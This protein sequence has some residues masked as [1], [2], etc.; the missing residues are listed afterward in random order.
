MSLFPRVPRSFSSA[1]RPLIRPPANR[2]LDYDGQ[3][4]A[5]IGK[6]GRRTQPEDANDLLRLRLC[7]RRHEPRL[8]ASRQIQRDAGQDPGQ[9][10]FH[11]L[12]AGARSDPAQLNAPP[13]LTRVIAAIRQ[14]NSLSRKMFPIR[15]RNAHGST[16]TTLQPGDVTITGTINDNTANAS[17][18]LGT[19][20]QAANAISRIKAAGLAPCILGTTNEARHA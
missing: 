13:F 5:M 2:T 17:V 1:Q 10:R 8:S 15:D 20:R 9:F 6:A 16:V 3:V 18:V 7:K 12:L 14:G 19:K 4:A 11:Q